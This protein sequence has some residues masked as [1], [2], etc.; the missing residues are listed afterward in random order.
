MKLGYY[1]ISA[2]YLSKKLFLNCL[3]VLS[4]SINKKQCFH[5]CIDILNLFWIKDISGFKMQSKI[6]HTLSKILF[7][8]IFEIFPLY[9][10]SFSQF[11]KEFFFQNYNV[12][13]SNGS[14]TFKRPKGGTTI[15][16]CSGAKDNTQRWIVKS[17]HSE[18]KTIKTI[19][20][21]LFILR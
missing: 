14:T 19:L 18:N 12:R 10:L 1:F 16:S 3:F 21:L 13:S 2:C 8:N 5:W 7:N 4:V 9:F 17:C 11:K 6:L 15:R 20:K